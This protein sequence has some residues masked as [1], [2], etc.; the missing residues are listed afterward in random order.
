[1]ITSSEMFGVNDF[2][3]RIDDIC[4][5]AANTKFPLMNIIRH[6]ED[7]ATVE[8]A[9]AGYDKDEIEVNLVPADQNIRLLE[10]SGEPL[11]ID[12]GIN[13]EVQQIAHRKFRTSL[14]LTEYWDVSNCEM[15]NGMLVVHLNRDLPEERKTRNIQI[16]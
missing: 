7:S 14:P 12:D 9:L 11:P 5:T 6:S 15:I 4:R 16:G 1:M 13:Y 3:T 10:V 2:L 8:M